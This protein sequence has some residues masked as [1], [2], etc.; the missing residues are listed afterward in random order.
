MLVG[1]VSYFS[2]VQLN[3]NT[4]WVA[5]THRVI[6]RIDSMLGRV[7]DA[8][9]AQR[10]YLI[11]GDE[12]YLAGYTEASRDARRGLEE[13][14]LAIADNP[15]QLQRFEEFKAVV[16][17][18]LASSTATITAY[19]SGGF[20]AAQEIVRGGRGRQL[21]EQLRDLAEEIK[22]AEEVLL[23][24]REI[25]AN[26]SAAFTQ[27]TI[28]GSGGLALVLVGVALAGIRRDLAARDQ[29]QRHLLQSEQTL[30]QDRAGLE[31]RV[32]AGTAELARSNEALRHSER[33]FRALIEHGSDC[34]ALIDVSEKFVYL[35]PAVTTIGSFAPE[36][37]VGRS[38]TEHMHPE[39]L[40][41]FRETMQKLLNNSTQ[42]DRILWRCRHKQGHWLWLEGAVTNLL[43]D[44]AVAAIVMNFR[45]VTASK[46]AELKLRSQLTRLALLSE[47]T[48]AIGE[49]QDIHSI[50][51][52]VVRA[53]EEELPADFACMCMYE[54]TAKTLTVTR[55]G[56]RSAELAGEL[57]LAEQAKIIID[58]NGLSQCVAGSL[59]YEPDLAKIPF[60]F[61]QRLHRGGLNCMVAAPLRSERTVFGV[62]VVARQQATSFSSGECEFLRQLSEH[63]ALAA[64]QAGLYSSLQAAYDD[65]RQSQQA[66]MQ[67][68]RLRVLGQMASG[69]AHDI[70]NAISPIALYTDSMLDSE[71]N[72]SARSRGYLQT[73][74]R[75][76]G[77][78]A[79]TVARMREFYRQ[80]EQQ[81]AHVPVQLNALLA[82]VV[83]LTRARWS[84][85]P[86]Q[87]GI[88]IQ[89]DTQLASDLPAVRGTEGEIRDALTNLIFNAVDAMPEGGVLTLRTSVVEDANDASNRKVNL[90]VIDSGVGMDEA[91]R[92]RCME[93]FFTTKGERGTGL[94][95]AMVYGMTQRHG[96]QLVVESEPGKGTMI[97][98]SFQAPPEINSLEVAPV[99]TMPPGLR[100]LVVDDDPV[101]LKSLRDTLEGAGINV[102]MAQGGQD[103]IDAFLAAHAGESVFDVVITDLG[104]PF[105]DGRKVA[106]AVKAASP[107]TPVI[108]LTGWGQRLMV[109]GD[110]PDNVDRVLSKPPRLPELR[111]ALAQLTASDKIQA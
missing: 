46:Q 22:N 49:R 36:E 88:V 48:R 80:R 67:Q 105:I 8:E 97:R 92:L 83:E 86:Q 81:T 34:I 14:Q 71:P 111:A 30:R 76:I 58:A 74:Q 42:P 25:K 3:E 91:T 104:M 9:T 89:L 2:V 101:L 85:M 16:I 55:I 93:L 10:G 27:T 82:Q 110:V 12:P 43:D 78:V 51:Q 21:H 11:S 20:K 41:K 65:L 47:I 77:D 40:P 23:Q 102:A 24:Q 72:L 70:N 28:I 50:F 109:E 107:E 53:V 31:L 69:V 38:A 79:E 33:R 56:V 18:R 39:D 108:M 52:V 35:S 19:Q 63:V 95:L 60:A 98:L 32:E 61:P 64:H 106:S 6:N 100:V 57:A 15:D 7:T 26:H 68:E 5:H 62:L 4:A 66:V 87:R 73:I 75:A 99:Y 37:L 54:P 44:P 13:L 17:E 45:D 29:A 59:V 1:A 90:D 84:D 103:G 94:G 96:A